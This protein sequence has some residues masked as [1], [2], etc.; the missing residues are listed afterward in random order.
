MDEEVKLKLER[1]IKEIE[2]YRGR[3]TELVTVYVP[4]GY[5]LNLITRQIEAEKSTAQNIKSTNTRKNVLDALERIS[6]HIKLYK[7]TPPNG[8]ALFAGN[9]SEKEGQEQIEVWG[10]EPPKPLRTKLYRCDQTFVVEP[11]KEMLEIEDVYGLVVIERKEA[12]IGLL[13]GKNIKV[14]RHMTSGVPGKFKTGGQSQ[15]RFHR[16]IEGMA[17]EFYK[18][19]AEYMKEEFF[20]MKKLRGII[21]GGPGPT[22]EDFLSMGELTTALKNKVIAVKDI[23]YADEHGLSLLVES[24]TDVLAKEEITREKAIIDRFFALLATKPEL[25][26]YGKEEVRKALMAGAVEELLISTSNSNADIDE[27]KELAKSTSTTINLI[28]EQTESGVQFRNLGGY[29]ARLR[30]QIEGY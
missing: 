9:I 23:G 20:E 19:I 7:E 16:I 25:A 21:V 22:K 24:S 26:S 3:H 18:R 11:L 10:I 15:Q 8:V 28:S 27:F 1:L 30:F 5:N 6:R 13:E 14:L 2:G 4:A 12:T 17:K 29:G